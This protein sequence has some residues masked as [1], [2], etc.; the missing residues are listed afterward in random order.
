[1]VK[2]SSLCRLPWLRDGATQ[3]GLWPAVCHVASTG[4]VA[5]TSA[6]EMGG[7]CATSYLYWPHISARCGA[8]VGLDF[9]VEK[10]V[11]MR[12]FDEAV[13]V[14]RDYQYLIMN[15]YRTCWKRVMSSGHSL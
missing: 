5:C 3:Q 15:I 6:M 10:G 11:H 7:A 12:F 13:E 1:M 8:F 9:R 14:K 4:T 2:L